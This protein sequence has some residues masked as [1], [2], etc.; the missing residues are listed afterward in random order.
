MPTLRFCPGCQ[1][2]G[3]TR[4]KVH[5]GRILEAFTDKGMFAPEIRMLARQ[6]ENLA[7]KYAPMRTGRLKGQHYRVILPPRG[8]TRDFYVGN[9]AGY[10]RFVRNGTANEGTGFIY[11]RPPK[12]LALRP[13]PY[14]YFGVNDPR[15]FRT[16][17]RGQKGFDWLGMALR[18]VM[19]WHFRN[20]KRIT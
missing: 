5:Y 7:V 11:A 2:G 15:R 6:V 17:V 3:Y 18:D 16:H 12:M 13:A 14:S 20:A 8:Y 1:G 9:K 19:N 4:T 10:A